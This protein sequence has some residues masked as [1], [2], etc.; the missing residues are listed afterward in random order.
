MINF[1]KNLFRRKKKMDNKLEIIIRDFL[2]SKRRQNMID[3]HNY[4]SNRHDVLKRKRE[5]INE[6]GE[7]ES[8][9]NVKVSKMT[10]NQY[11]KLIDQKTNYMLSK[12]PSLESKDKEYSR[13]VDDILN[14]KFF[15]TLKLIGKDAYRYGIGWLYVYLDDEGEL[16]FKRFDSRDIIPV[17]KDDEHDELDYAIRLYHRREYINGSFQNTVK[18]EVYTKNGVEYYN[19][20]NNLELDREA[21][22]YITVKSEDGESQKYNWVKIPLI[23]FR[24]DESETPILNRIKSLQDALNELLSVMQDRVEEDPR[25]TILIIKNYDGT[26]WSEFRHNL[27][28]HGIIPVRSD[29]TGDSGVESLKIEINVQ[30][31]KILVDL[32]KKAIIENGRGFDSKNEL[33][34][35]N[36]NQL[37]IR[38]MYSDIDLDAN[39]MEVEFKASFQELIWFI[40]QYLK[41]TGGI[42]SEEK[43]DII[44]NKDIL[45]NESQVIAD[46]KA[47]VG[48]LSEETLITQHP[49]TVNP[50]EELERVEKERKK[51]F[52]DYGTFEEYNHKHEENKRG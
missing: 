49:Y 33:L 22:S 52:E 37:N 16:K 34:G 18:V 21:D 5:M 15:K 27:K 4:Y 48:I 12:T 7:L 10:D 6:N 17:W 3:S 50:K 20:N 42:T 19:W 24:Y 36:P 26:D 29:D 14:N 25:N 28:V 43:I 46:I 40:N 11:A 41:N 23:P 44:F 32:L 1:I 45:I 13:K 38:S 47:S 8:I 9:K 39:S 30:N 31:Y 2:A 35:G 51:N